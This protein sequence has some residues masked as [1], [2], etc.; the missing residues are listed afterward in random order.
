MDTSSEFN[1]PV[2]AA[3]Q[4][5]STLPPQFPPQP[6]Q[7]YYPQQTY[8]PTQTAYSPTQTA[9]PPQTYPP[10]QQVYS[11]TATSTYYSQPGLEVGSTAQYYAQPEEHTASS[12]GFFTPTTIPISDEHDVFFSHPTYEVDSDD[13]LW[14]LLAYVLSPLVPI[15]LFLLPSKR[16]RPFIK[17]HTAQSFLLGLVNLILWSVLT[18]LLSLLFIIPFVLWLGLVFLGVMAYRGNEVNIPLLTPWLQ[19]LGMA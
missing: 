12:D 19:G 18:W 8:S 6:A 14:C 13:K 11:P 5:T 4:T 2:H 9:Y 17:A 7:A 10:Q 1:N 16:T 3:Y 15:I